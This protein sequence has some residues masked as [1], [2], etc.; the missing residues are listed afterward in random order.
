MTDHDIQIAQDNKD[1][2][3]LLLKDI[4]AQLKVLSDLI[5]EYEDKR[6]H[7]NYGPY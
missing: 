5:K 7:V 6:N 4:K 3:A 2:D 1:A